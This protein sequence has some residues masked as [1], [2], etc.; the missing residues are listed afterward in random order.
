[1]WKQLKLHCRTALRLQLCASTQVCS[2][3]DQLV[4]VLFVHLISLRLPVWTFD[5]ANIRACDT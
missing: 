5:A 3:L 2:H 1:M 4:G